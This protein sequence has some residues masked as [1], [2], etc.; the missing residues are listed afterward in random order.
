MSS[1]GASETEK[2]VIGARKSVYRAGVGVERA[3]H[4]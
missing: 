1:K 3:E 2:L 4:A